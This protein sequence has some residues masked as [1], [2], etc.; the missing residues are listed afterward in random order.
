MRRPIKKIMIFGKPGSGKS[1]FA[2]RLAQKL[3][4]PVYH[5]DKYFFMADWTERD[6]DD[7]LNIQR[8]FVAKDA[9]IIEGNALASLDVR[10]EKAD[11]VLYFDFPYRVCISRIVRR[12]FGG[13][14]Q[15]VD[16]QAEGRPRKFPWKLFRYLLTF[17]R[18]AR[19]QLVLLQDMWPQVPLK[20]VTHD[21]EAEEV[22]AWLRN[23]AKDS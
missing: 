5:L 15:Q 14:D 8:S 3:N 7:F 11:L 12:H 16:D 17:R 10:F 2:V 20:T 19:K 21:R 23:H 1:T 4:L 6:A 18:R 9:W 13:R 22:L